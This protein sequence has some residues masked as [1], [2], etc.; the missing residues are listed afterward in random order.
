MRA[1][2]VA[3]ST[4]WKRLGIF[5]RQSST[6]MRAMADPKEGDGGRLGKAERGEDRG[7]GPSE[8]CVLETLR[9][10]DRLE[11]EQRRL[12]QGVDYNEV[13]LARL[14]N[15]GTR[16]LHPSLDHLEAVLAASRQTLAQLLP[17]RRQHENQHRVGKE[18][19]DLQRALPV[20]LEDDVEATDDARLDRRLRR[21]VEVAVDLGP[22]DEL[23]AR[24]HRAER[25]LVGEVVF[26]A[27]LVLAARLPGR[28]RDR[29]DEVRV[30]LEQRVDE[31]RLAGAARGGNGEEGAGQGSGRGQ[32]AREFIVAPWN[33]R[34][35]CRAIAS[36]GGAM[37]RLRREP[38]RVAASLA[39]R[40]SPQRSA[41]S[42]RR[43]CRRSH[44]PL[45]SR[46]SSV[47]WPSRAT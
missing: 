2:Y 5:S 6:V 15:L 31:G 41:P 39:D 13:E 46:W 28:V 35:R 21:A 8:R 18:L 24:D 9:V 30:E 14:P 19:L 20:D 12:E 44:A 27:V 42:R 43:S 1:R 34:A 25:R 36:I 38:A 4:S 29:D 47:A 16:V 22:L 26:A 37:S 40:S 3:A 10:D 33:L 32:G 11:V 7:P 45:P 23:A 17:A